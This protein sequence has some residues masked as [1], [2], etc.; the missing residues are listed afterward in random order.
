MLVGFTGS[1]GRGQQG[2]KGGDLGQ[3]R[4]PATVFTLWNSQGSRDLEVAAMMF[5]I[6]E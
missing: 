6:W 4:T 2:V 1:G 5:Y 3:R